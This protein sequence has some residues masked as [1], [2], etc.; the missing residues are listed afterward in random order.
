MNRTNLTRTFALWK[1]PSNI[2]SLVMWAIA[3]HS[4]MVGIGLVIRPTVLMEVFGFGT[5][6]ERFFPTQGGIFH[7]VMAI[8][9]GMAAFNPDDHYSLV[10]FA[11]I[12]KTVA[13]VYLLLYYLLIDTLLIVFLSGVIDGMMA[14]AIWLTNRYYHQHRNR[15]LSS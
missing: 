6:Y 2:L 5:C 13:A 12:V 8:G 9:Y 14:G 4:L 3:L 1:S 7:I 15:V 10:R 11:L